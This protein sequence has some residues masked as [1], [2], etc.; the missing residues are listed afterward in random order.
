MVKKILNINLMNVD[1]KNILYLVIFVN[2]IKQIEQIHFIHIDYFN[3]LK[4][5][6][7]EGP[8]FSI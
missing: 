5:L 8:F 7:L 2:V 4:Y 6:F 3:R 1:S